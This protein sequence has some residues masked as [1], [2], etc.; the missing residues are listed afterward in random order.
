MFKICGCTH[1]AADHYHLTD[2]CKISGCGCHEFI[3]DESKWKEA[4]SEW[5]YE[6]A[7]DERLMSEAF[8]QERL[9][10]EDND[11]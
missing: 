3:A 11:E 9:E 1:S 6:D 10:V 8:H 5:D 7:E 4:K 2:S